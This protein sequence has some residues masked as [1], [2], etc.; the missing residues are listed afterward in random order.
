VTNEPRS[1]R[2]TP[3]RAARAAQPLRLALLAL[4]S[5][6]GGVEAQGSWQGSGALAA[7]DPAF[8]RA[9]LFQG[10]CFPSSVGS[11]V[12]YDVHE[13]ILDNPTPPTQLTASLCGGGTS[14]D[15]VLFFY[16]HSNGAPGPFDPADPCLRLVS[17]N[18]DFCGAQSSTANAALAA[19]HLSIVVTSYAND[20]F[21]SYALAATSNDAELDPFI[22]YSGFET[23]DTRT[24]SSTAP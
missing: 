16:Q 6:A 3:G 2:S 22:F 10:S 7:S 12:R 11:A 9:Y 14:F 19:G 18:D 21:G 20:T 5:G 15:S 17:Y 1:D 23:Q 24:W 8:Q 13:L 4:L